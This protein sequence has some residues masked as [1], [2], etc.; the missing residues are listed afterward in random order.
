M[1]AFPTLTR[2]NVLA[3]LSA[4][5]ALSYL[6]A[7]NAATKLVLS[8]G[9]PESSHMLRNIHLFAQA[10]NQGSGGELAMEAYGNAALYK[11]PE[12]KRAVQTGQVQLGELFLAGMANED[13]IYGLEALP[14]LVKDVKE[15]ALLWQ[16]QKPLVASRFEKS[17]LKLLFGVVW[18]GQSLFSKKPVQSFADLQGTKFRVQ[19]PG[20]ARL[21]EL[22]KVTGVRVETAD[23]PQAFLTG[24]I[25]GMYTSNAT[26][27]GAA[28]WDYCKYIYE[29][30]AW[31]PKNVVFINNKVFE[32]LAPK[33]K[34]LVLSEAAKAETRGWELEKG[35][36][37]KANALLRKNGVQI[38]PPSAQL[39]AEFRK[40]GQVMAD[41]WVATAGP[42]GKT[43]LQQFRQKAG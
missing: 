32:G 36:T 13:P 5:P 42:E 40:V 12:T 15:A 19:S 41:E 37:E 4:M 26:G 43:L 9:F 35:E 2:R 38:A 23:L 10:L 8:S 22:M 18:P 20:T 27:A 6:K 28:S 34:E 31:Y 21:A 33:M 39:M 3:A 24:I 11:L 30:N 17:G 7:G 16:L 14:F 29:T 1:S 25:D